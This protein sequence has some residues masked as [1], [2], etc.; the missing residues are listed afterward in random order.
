MAIFYLLHNIIPLGSKKS[1]VTDGQRNCKL[2]MLGVFIYVMIYIYMKNIQL[3][4]I[5]HEE[6]YESL[7][8][9]FYVM[10]VADISVMSFIYKDYYGRSI[11]HEVDETI[12]SKVKD[13]RLHEYDE[14]KHMYKRKINDDIFLTKDFKKNKN[15]LQNLHKTTSSKSSNKNI[16]IKNNKMEN[17]KIENNDEHA[18]NNKIENNDEHA[19]N[20]KNVENNELNDKQIKI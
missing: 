13:E 12:N 11:L 5:I 9:G 18:E 14:D 8:V 6:W 20:N 15:D 10:L 19:E 3:I 17:N 4:G 16:S 1:G 7:K 2:F